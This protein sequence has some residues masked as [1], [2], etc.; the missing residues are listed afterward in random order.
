MRTPKRTVAAVA[1][2]TMTLS[3]MACSGGSKAGSGA[4]SGPVD[5]TMTVWTADKDVIGAYEAMA[6]TFK[7]DHPD[8]RNFTVQSIPFANY[9]GRLTTQLSGGDAPDLGWLVEADTPGM[10]ASGVLVDVGPTLRK[11]SSYEFEDIL[12]NTLTV[13]QRDDKL[14]G[15]PFANTTQPIIFNADLFAQAGV[16]SPVTLLQNGQW[17]WENLARISRELVASGKAKYGFDIPQF[18]YKNYQLFTPIMKAFGAEA[19]P[20]GTKCG[21]DSPESVAA[22]NFLRTMIYND[23]SYPAPGES[24]SFPTGDTGM[25]LG[26]PSTL[27]QLKDAKFKFDVVPQPSG[28]KGFD[29]FFGQAALVVFKNGTRPEL[30]TQLLAFFTNKENSQTLSRF[31]ITPRKSLLTPELVAKSNPLL[32][33]EAAKRSMVDP[34]PAAKQIDYPTTLPELNSALI[35]VMDALWQPKADV[36]QILT[37]AC[38]KAKPLLPTK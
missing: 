16:D 32:T 21:Y 14:F 2:L 13:L 23:N 22:V 24:P 29:P 30:A 5:L 11:D 7:A 10:A 33:A 8:L 37:E 4:T 25:Y 35:P 17:T 36:Q 20:G 27:N 6:K 12:P 1:A 19:W 38:V 3:L 34:L 26:P 9:V 28:T 31:F 15:Y 18:A